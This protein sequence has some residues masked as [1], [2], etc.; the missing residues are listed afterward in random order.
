MFRNRPSVAWN[1]EGGGLES[2][3]ATS[4]SR[5]V[6]VTL[7]RQKEFSTNTL[8]P[9]LA[10]RRIRRSTQTAPFFFYRQ[11]HDYCESSNKKHFKRQKTCRRRGYTSI[12]VTT[13][14]VCDD[15]S[16]TTCLYYH[17]CLI[18]HDEK[19]LGKNCLRQ[20]RRVWRVHTHT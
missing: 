13:R 19:K 8:V 3:M 4:R 12:L 1:M 17:T 18:F 14:L 2:S 16:P 9:T 11:S 6:A 15:M 5:N 7:K 20:K 10:F